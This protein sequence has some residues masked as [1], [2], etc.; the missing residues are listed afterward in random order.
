MLKHWSCTVDC[1]EVSVKAKALCIF[2]EAASGSVQP[3]GLGFMLGR[4]FSCGCSPL[5]SLLI[6]WDS[7]KIHTAL[8]SAG[9]VCMVAL[10]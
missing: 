4:K 5:S 1:K 7:V 8:N 6:V 10:L 2:K 3:S 9:G